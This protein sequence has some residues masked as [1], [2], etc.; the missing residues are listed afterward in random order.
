MLFMTD[1]WWLKHFLRDIKHRKLLSLFSVLFVSQCK[2]SNSSQ[3]ISMAQNRC[4]F[5]LILISLNLFVLTAIILIIIQFS[6]YFM[7]NKLKNNICHTFCDGFLSDC[8]LSSCKSTKCI[9]LTLIDSIVVFSL[10][11]KIYSQIFT[12]TALLST[13]WICWQLYLTT[14]IFNIPWITFAI[15]DCSKTYFTILSNERLMSGSHL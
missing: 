12:I 15:H 9:K 6:L 3:G 10:N 11:L 2:T 7:S 5:R 8:L 14:L 4:Y 1:F 13:D